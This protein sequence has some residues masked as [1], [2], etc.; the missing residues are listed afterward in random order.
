MEPINRKWLEFMREQYPKGSRIKLREM[1]DP[2]HPVPPGTMGTLEHIDDIGTFHVKWDNG[3]S[4]GLVMGEDSFTVLPPQ[5]TTLKLF[6]PLTADLYERDEWGC[7]GEESTPL[8]GRELLQ[9]EGTILQALRE[10]QLPEE[11]ERGIMHWYH[12]DD[13]VNKKVQSVVF[14]VEQRDRKLWGV[15]ECKVQ[16]QLTPEE[17]TALADFISGQASD[18]WGEGFEQHDISPDDTQLLRLSAY[19][20]RARTWPP[21]WPCSL[22]P[23]N[24]SPRTAS[25]VS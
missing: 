1:K 4:L 10:N 15:A 13:S 18:G 22:R 17:M 25:P 24:S 9:Y 11:A 19:P 3:S 23:R 2:Y 20:A 8:E 21:C 5:P 16:G 7:Y 6:F 12:E 14:T